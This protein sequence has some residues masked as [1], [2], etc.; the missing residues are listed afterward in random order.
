M[1]SRKANPQGITYVA[2]WWCWQWQH[3]Q[4][5]N[6]RQHVL[7][8]LHQQGGTSH[9]LIHLSH[10]LQL[11]QC[12]FSYSYSSQ[13]WVYLCCPC[14]QTS[15]PSCHPTMDA[16]VSAKICFCWIQILYFKLIGFGFVTYSLLLAIY[17][18]HCSIAVRH[19]LQN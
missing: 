17:Y 7:T 13:F 1:P 19:S 14:L 15:F 11:H 4:S 10:V 8:V 6:A 16:T 2:A 18:S 5:I 3:W 12:S 9:Q